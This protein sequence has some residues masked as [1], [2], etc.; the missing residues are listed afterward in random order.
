MSNADLLKAI[1]SIRH[2]WELKEKIRE[3]T[4]ALRERELAQ[5]HKDLEASRTDAQDILDNANHEAERIIGDAKTEAEQFYNTRAQELEVREN[6]HLKEINEREEKVSLQHEEALAKE[7]KGY[8]E[9]QARGYEEGYQDGMKQFTEMVESLGR[10]LE[11]IR[12][13]RLDLTRQN[14]QFIHKFARL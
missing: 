2:E 14:L 6:E 12:A 11:E 3:A 8:E 7:A 4:E 5:I 9:G 1:E 13:Q 10:V